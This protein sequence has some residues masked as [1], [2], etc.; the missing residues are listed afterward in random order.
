MNYTTHIS[1]RRSGWLGQSLTG[2]RAYFV[3]F[4]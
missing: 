3:N 2:R 1:M 4:C